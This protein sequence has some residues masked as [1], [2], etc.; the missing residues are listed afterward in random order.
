VGVLARGQVDSIAGMKF[1][2]RKGVRN[3]CLL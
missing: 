3:Y 2:V 1:A